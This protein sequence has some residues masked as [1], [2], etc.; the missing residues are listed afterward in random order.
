MTHDGASAGATGGR[1]AGSAALGG[2]TSTPSPAVSG[3]PSG[4]LVESKVKVIGNYVLTSRTLGKGN[5]ARVEEAQHTATKAKVRTK[6][7]TFH[8]PTQ[9]YKDVIFSLGK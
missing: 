6:I 2:E 4:G 1:A 8:S 3:A 5:F 9:L 7:S